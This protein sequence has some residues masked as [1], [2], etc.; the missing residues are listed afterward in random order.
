VG[1]QLVAQRHT[2][3]AA[4]EQSLVARAA[5]TQQPVV[6]NDVRADPGFLPNPLLPATRS[7]LALPLVVGSRL[8]GVLDV[9]ADTVNRFTAEDVQVQAT[10]AAQVAVALQNAYLYAEQAATVTRLREIDHL[11]SS[12]LANMSHELRTPLNSILGFTDVM[13]EGLDGEITDR[14]ATDLQVI[15]KNGHHLLNLI[16]D[17]LDMAKIEAGK[18]QLTPEPFNLEEVLDEVLSIT[19]PLADAKALNLFVDPAS[20]R[21]LALEAD[22]FRLR[23]VMLNLVNNAIKFTDAGSVSISAERENG[24]IRVAVQDTGL[25]IPADHLELIFQEF[26]QVDISS[27]RKVGGTGLGLPISR[28]LVELHGGRLWAESTGVP[29]EGSRFI[30]ELPVESRYTPPPAG[31]L[32]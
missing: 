16:N 13:L 31:D 29:G 28:K 6:V 25:G 15:Q 23:Q 26:T 8:L 3:P 10:L 2:I 12:F 20:S 22:R 24:G 14:M 21:D 1:R 4:L 32:R 19:A 30:M 11:K 5:R 17:V 7:E 27:T 9:Q 18:L